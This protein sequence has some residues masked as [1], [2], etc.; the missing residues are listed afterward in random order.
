MSVP[1]I[2]RAEA[3]RLAKMSAYCGAEMPASVIIG[4]SVVRGYVGMNDLR[5]WYSYCCF[6]VNGVNGDLNA[7]KAFGSV[8]IRM[9]RHYAIHTIRPEYA[10]TYGFVTSNNS[11]LT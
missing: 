8:E 11:L 9:I 2:V 7:Q 10:R 3:C 1:K 4:P 5:Y 6:T